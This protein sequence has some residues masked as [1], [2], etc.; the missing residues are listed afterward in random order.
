MKTILIKD[1][2]H[3]FRSG[4]KEILKIFPNVR[5]FDSTE[6]ELYIDLEIDII[7]ADIQEKDKTRTS[8][9]KELK[10]YA[11]DSKM[12]VFTT[13]DN[14]HLKDDVLRTGADYFL[15]KEKDY[16]V[17]IDILENCLAA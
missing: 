9:V 1:S 15:T 6:N 8:L 16:G 17:L 10:N 3:L 13:K 12:I 11:P 4:L 2:S 5:V 7:I 14:Y